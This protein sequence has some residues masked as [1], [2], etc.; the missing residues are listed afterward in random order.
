MARMPSYP[1]F[2]AYLAAQARPHQALR[3]KLRRR[4]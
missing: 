1:S 2:A 4:N 3:A